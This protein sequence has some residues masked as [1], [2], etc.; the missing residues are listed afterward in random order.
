[1]M[2]VVLPWIFLFS[3]ATSCW[4]WWTFVHVNATRHLGIKP[5]VSTNGGAESSIVNVSMCVA[6]GRHFLSRFGKNSWFVV[7]IRRR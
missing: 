3:S 6:Q 1:M 7:R 4:G 2:C 5:R